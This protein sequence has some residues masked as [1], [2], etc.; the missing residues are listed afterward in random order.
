MNK[1]GL[2]VFGLAAALALGIWLGDS[3][4]IKPTLSAL[5]AGSSWLALGLAR[6]A[7]K[8]LHP[9]LF[10]GLAILAFFC[11]GIL[12]VS[13]ETATNQPG[14]YARTMG[15]KRQATAE[16]PDFG[17][18]QF[19]LIHL[20]E[21]MK[22]TSYS[23]RWIGRIRQIGS[24]K[25]RGRV[26]LNFPTDTPDRNWQPE[27]QILLYG[28]IEAF[29]PPLNPG[30]FDYASYMK[31]SGIPGR[32]RIRE[33]AF[34]YRSVPSEGFRIQI[35]RLRSGLIRILDSSGL[36]KE[37]ASM[38]RALLLGDRSGIDPEL[39][40]AYQ[41]AGVVHLLAISGLHVGLLLAL[42]H[43]ILSPLL[44]RKSRML[45]FV[46]SLT[47]LWGYAILAGLGPSVVRA[48]VMFSLWALAVYMRREGESLHFL[49]LAALLMLGI[50]NPY[51]LFQAGFQLSFAAVWGI[52]A[53]AP[54]FRSLRP[55]KNPI[56]AKIGGWIGVSLAAQ[57][58]VLPLSLYHFHQFPWMFLAGSLLLVPLLGILLGLALAFMLLAVLG[59]TPAWL[60]SIL[61]GT[62][63]MQNR[64]VRI[65]ASWDGLL[66]DG[67]RWDGIHLCLAYMSLFGL[68]LAL[69]KRSGH[70]ARPKKISWSNGLGT[71]GTKVPGLGTKASLGLAALSLLGL[72][73]WALFSDAMARRQHQWIVPHKTAESVFWVREGQDFYVFSESE[74]NPKQA[75]EYIRQEGLDSVRPRSMVQ[76]YRAGSKQLLRIDSDGTYPEVGY[77]A[78]I[79][80]LSGSPKIHLGRVIQRLS[81][82]L[83][84]ADGSNYYSDLDRWGSSCREAGIPFHATARNGAYI[85]DLD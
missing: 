49:G 36:N 53:F 68:Y 22:S 1:T 50:L 11:F 27:D 71:S 77:H 5:L 48:A 13:L 75:L 25:V 55:Y 73:V 41:R 83:V 30:Q 29:G 24:R 56:P 3:L 78:D 58:G 9:C 81:P 65:L 40:E 80:L 19:M 15:E 34:R 43:V 17:D 44:G 57:I 47:A 37:A 21:R 28:H 10:P 42:V 14:H 39:R 8:R 26:L 82:S 84:V 18:G 54:I 31:T 61:N 74:S 69:R 51:W 60:A 52:L 45:R 2:A 20:G 85:L 59:W 70:R 6:F 67:I 7:E 16:D 79:V 76:A 35:R 38:T 62:L 12:R 72:Q 63:G 23:R 66:I 64:L 33:E 32:I 4:G 46:V